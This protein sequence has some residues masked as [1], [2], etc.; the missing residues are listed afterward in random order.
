ME[1]RFRLLDCWS[2][3]GLSILE[4]NVRVSSDVLCA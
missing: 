2:E 3:S 4:Y 1:V